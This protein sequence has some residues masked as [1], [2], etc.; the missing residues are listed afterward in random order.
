MAETNG[1][2][3]KAHPYLPS[4]K[5]RY[6]WLSSV[7]GLFLVAYFFLMSEP[8]LISFYEVPPILFDYKIKAALTAIFF[9]FLIH[10]VHRF[11][12]DRKRNRKQVKR[13]QD[14]VDQLWQSRKQL[15]Q[16]VHTYAGHADKLKLF[17]SDKLLEYIEYDEKFLHFKSIAAEVR[18]N[19]VIGFDKVQSVLEASLSRLDEG[20]TGYGE[21]RDALDQLRY[22]W[23]LLDL[24]TTD[25][26]A[27]HIANQ[28]CDL[29]EQYYQQVLDPDAAATQSLQPDFSP[30]R[31]LERALVPLLENGPAFRAEL[32]KGLPC[33]WRDDAT[34]WVDIDPCG[35]LLGLENHWVLLL[36]NLLKNA[37][38]FS[39]KRPYRHKYRRVAVDLSERDGLARITVF[40]GGPPISEEDQAK[41]FQ[42]GY[43]TRKVKEHHGKGLGLFFVGEIAKGYEGRV[44]ITN[45]ANTAGWLSI[46][47]TLADGRVL[48]QM[49]DIVLDDELPRVRLNPDDTPDKQLDFEYDQTITT[50]EVSRAG[51]T[52]PHSL[53]VADARSRST[54]LDPATPGRPAWVLD[55]HNKGRQASASFQPLDVRGVEFRVEVPLAETRLAG[56]DP[57]R[58]EEVDVDRLNEPFRALGTSD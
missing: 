2:N 47:V 58:L 26:I 24:A 27:L 51:Q 15:Q 46:R 42:L 23:D 6:G 35:P 53:T 19:G 14:E 34:F 25:N 49:V 39:G 29:E 18:H 44:R 36:E 20:D 16:K 22:L 3:G 30:V 52:E 45:V 17:I 50:V 7:F 38:F 5:L 9:I 48:T 8:D 31:A 43:S 54:W 21:T 13:F 1:V 32:A 41:V 37:Q 33:R 40:N 4:L 57:D 12:R 11:G 28:L 10:D 56:D 55:I